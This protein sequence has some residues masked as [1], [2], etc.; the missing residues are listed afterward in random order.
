[1]EKFKE[2][3]GLKQLPE[4]NKQLIKFTLIGLLAVLTDLVF[5][6]LFLN[7]LP[8][9]ATDV[10]SNEALAK[11]MSFICGIFVTYNLNKYWTWRKRDRSNRRLAKFS[12]LY[13][14]SLLLN[15]AVNTLMLFLLHEYQDVYDIPYKYFVAFIAATGASAAFN[16]TGQKFWVFREGLAESAD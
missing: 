5:Y 14:A 1:M 3:T 11:A 13:G 10:F 6:Y 12:A 16:F 7:V 8:L 2:K 15:V 9:R 4:F